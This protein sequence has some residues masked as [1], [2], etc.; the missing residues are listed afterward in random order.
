[1][2]LCDPNLVPVNLDHYGQA[3]LKY[4]KQLTVSLLEALMW[5]FAIKNITNKRHNLNLELCFNC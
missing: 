4:V 3:L 1:M 5:Y 2:R